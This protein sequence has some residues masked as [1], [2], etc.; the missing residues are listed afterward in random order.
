MSTIQKKQRFRGDVWFDQQVEQRT[1]K[2][3]HQKQIE[4]ASAHKEDT[5]EQL[6]TYVRQAALELGYTPNAGEMIGGEYISSRFG[7]WGQVVQ[8]AGLSP[9]GKLRD[10]KKRQIYKEEF[11]RQAALFK[12]ERREQK[13]EKKMGVLE[14]HDTAKR[15]QLEQEEKNY[16]WSA[17]H[18]HDTD[19]QLLEYL[20]QCAKELG[21][22]PTKAEV[23]GSSY[24]IKRFVSWPLAL[25]LANLPLPQG[26]KPPKPKDI[27][28][29]RRLK[30][31]R[32]AAKQE[33][34]P[35]DVLS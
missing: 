7:N 13:E 16:A 17:Q 9:Q 2:A 23:E 22:S 28:D 12:R 4:F 34:D 27:N 26:M 29:Y 21:H 8:A 31:Q 20:Q 18:E 30:K 5:N 15:D 35:N 19:E 11:K 24:I 10:I 25:Q 1:K 3:L 14:R 32:N 6:L 33:K